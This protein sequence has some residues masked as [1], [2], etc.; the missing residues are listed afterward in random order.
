VAVA[1]TGARRI[2]RVWLT[3]ARAGQS[4]VLAD[5]LWGYPDNI[6]L[7][8]DGLIW[9]ALAGPRAASLAAVQRLPGAVR[10]MV[11]RLP[12]RLQ[13]APDPA[14]GVVALDDA[15]RV[16]HRLSGTIDGFTMLTG[17]RE[18]GGTL[19]FGSLTGDCVATLTR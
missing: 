1:E 3:G 13:P 9:V 5:D 11:R 14:V 12:D 8:S 18:S 19:W 10:A 6:A 17:V 16:V 15:G 2:R 4:D 7:G